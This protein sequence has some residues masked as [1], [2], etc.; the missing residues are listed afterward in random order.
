MPQPVVIPYVP[1]TI[2]VHLGPPDSDAA[3]VTVPFPDYVKNTCQHFHK[4]RKTT[5]Q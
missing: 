4:C 1:R 5:L 2:T 3:N